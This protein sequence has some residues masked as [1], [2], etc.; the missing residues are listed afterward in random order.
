MGG[1]WARAT[2]S[3]IICFVLN[4]VAC[5]TYIQCST[6]QAAHQRK[7]PACTMGFPLHAP[8]FVLGFPKPF[9][10]DLGKVEADAGEGKG[11]RFPFTLMGCSL[12]TAL[13]TSLC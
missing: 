3:Y 11:E 12:S 13:D 2:I 7:I 1:K 6:K 5:L 9:R 10:A 4:V 8:S